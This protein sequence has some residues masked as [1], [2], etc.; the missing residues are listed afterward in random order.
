LDKI[1]TDPFRL[2]CKVC[3]HL[4]K[5]AAEELNTLPQKQLFNSN[6][7]FSVYQVVY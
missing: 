6:F 4:I 2:R 1:S 3:L 7:P 5:P